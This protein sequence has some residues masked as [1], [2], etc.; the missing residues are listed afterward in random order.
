M[1]IE[2]NK[3]DADLFLKIYTSVGWEPPCK[4]QVGEWDGPG[5]FKMI[6]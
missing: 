1:R 5:M 2:I 4:E 3:L 6:R